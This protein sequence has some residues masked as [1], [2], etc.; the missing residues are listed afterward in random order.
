MTLLPTRPH[1]RH[2]ASAPS[3]RGSGP[4]VAVLAAL[5]ACCAGSAAAQG[6]TV[7]RYGLTLGSDTTEYMTVKSGGACTQSVTAPWA[8]PLGAPPSL[9]EREV[10]LSGL[11]LVGR[12]QN[13]FA[14]VSGRATYAYKARPGYVG[15]DRFVVL[16][17]GP[18]G[19]SRITVEVNVV[20]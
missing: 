1:R 15:R 16:A 19:S 18:G 8:G 14:G 5:L 6:C 13:G 17:R 10:T 9:E 2:P 7:V 4:A 20:P 3:H 12:A 11:S